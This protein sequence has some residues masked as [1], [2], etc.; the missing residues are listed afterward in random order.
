MDKDKDKCVVR[1][2]GPSV[3]G[4]SDLA[5]RLD[6]PLQ[7]VCNQEEQG[8]RASPY[9]SPRLQVIHDLG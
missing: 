6:Q 4:M 3:R 1:G 9:R 2:H 8:D 5:H 7:D